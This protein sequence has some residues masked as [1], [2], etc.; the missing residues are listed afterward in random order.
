MQAF[1][2]LTSE[3]G[4]FCNNRVSDRL[5]SKDHLLKNPLFNLC[6]FWLKNQF[7]SHSFKRLKECQASLLKYILLICGIEGTAKVTYVVE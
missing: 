6:K 4:S 1:R 7:S 2:D 3:L 5:A